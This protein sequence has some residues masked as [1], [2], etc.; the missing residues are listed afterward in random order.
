[1]H[2]LPPPDRA[3]A[4]LNAADSGSPSARLNILE[5]LP[6]GAHINIRGPQHD[7]IFLQAIG[8]AIG[9]SLPLKPNTVEMLV[10]GAIY[11]LGPDEWLLVEDS[12]DTEALLLR[13]EQCCSAI[14]HFGATDVS[15]NRAR[16]Q[17]RGPSAREVLMKGC[18]LD[19]DPRAFQAG[20]CAQVALARAGVILHQVDAIPTYRIFPR[21]SFA[22]YVWMWLRDAMA[23]Y[24]G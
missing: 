24:E 22:E 11:W 19:L 23:E 14:P 3:T 5:E 17:L 4:R 10:R 20:Q 6:A 13:I 7:S 8:S 2:E 15:G 1:M 12:V 21:R 9:G 16:F 18:S